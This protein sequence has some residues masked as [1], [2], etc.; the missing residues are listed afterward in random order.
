MK[1][2][3]TKM[4]SAYNRLEQCIVYNSWLFRRHKWRKGRKSKTEQRP[5]QRVIR[6]GFFLND[7][8]VVHNF[9]TVL[10]LRLRRPCNVMQH[11][12]TSCSQLRL[13]L[14]SNCDV[15]AARNKHVHFCLRSCTRLQPITMHESVWAWSTSCGVFVYCYFYAFLLISKGDL[16]FSVMS[17]FDY[18]SMP[19][20]MER[21]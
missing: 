21:E 10:W 13:R 9:V 17:L 20:V 11:R 5:I 19:Y 8:S 16:L 14:W 15:T 7:L 6:S 2:P 1:I 12:A 3:I 18:T 4:R